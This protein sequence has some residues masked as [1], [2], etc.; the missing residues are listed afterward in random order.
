MLYVIQI[1][2]L[3]FVI[4]NLY[5]DKNIAHLQSQ[6]IEVHRTG[7][8]FLLSILVLQILSIAEITLN[9]WFETANDSKNRA[10]EIYVVEII[11]GNR[12][13]F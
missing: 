2:Y 3:L 8:W 12:I 4:W 1:T 10:T 9:V 13:K 5:S 7:D 6:A 11:E